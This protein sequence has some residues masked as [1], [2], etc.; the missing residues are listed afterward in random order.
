MKRTSAETATDMIAFGRVAPLVAMSRKK[1]A[2]PL[3]DQCGLSRPVSLEAVQWL[4]ARGVD[5]TLHVAARRGHVAMV[6]LLLDAGADPSIRDTE[7]N[8]DAVGWAEFF[9]QPEVARLLR[10]HGRGR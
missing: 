6:R 1:C 2:R 10:E 4:L 8:G 9:K 5:V 3:R 7:H